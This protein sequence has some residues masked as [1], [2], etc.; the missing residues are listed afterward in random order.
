MFI[1]KDNSFQMP[2]LTL[3]CMYRR[4]SLCCRARFSISFFSCHK[5]LAFTNAIHFGNHK[6]AINQRRSQ[7]IAVQSKLRQQSGIHDL[8]VSFLNNVKDHRPI[9]FVISPPTGETW[10]SFAAIV[11]IEPKIIRKKRKMQTNC[12]FCL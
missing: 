7:L 11:F 3:L 10:V 1:A 9:W 6:A 12:S 4:L 5:N 8:V 2:L